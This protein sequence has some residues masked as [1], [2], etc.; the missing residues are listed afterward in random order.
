MTAGCFE[1]ADAT[2]KHLGA[3]IPV[4]VLLWSIGWLLPRRAPD[5]FATCGMI[6]IAL[7]G[8]ASVRLNARE[9]RSRPSP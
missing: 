6:L 4:L 9:A 5:R 8:T 3:A 1:T 2:V 7:G